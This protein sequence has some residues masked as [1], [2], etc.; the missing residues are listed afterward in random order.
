MRKEGV[1]PDKKLRHVLRSQAIKQDKLD[2][3]NNHFP[4]DAPSGPKIQKNPRWE[5]AEATIPAPAPGAKYEPENNMVIFPNPSTLIVLQIC[6]LW[7]QF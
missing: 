1:E 4:Q 5:A 3:F 7:K 6:F 2:L